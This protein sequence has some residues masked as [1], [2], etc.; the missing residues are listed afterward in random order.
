VAAGALI[1]D[2]AGGMVSD[3]EGGLFDPFAGRAL[4]S[5]GLIHAEM[6]G[7]LRGNGEKASGGE[8]P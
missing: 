1:V 3:F 6:M 7:V 2:E 5:N 4:A 8:C